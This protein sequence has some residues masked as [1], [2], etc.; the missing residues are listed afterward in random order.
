MDKEE[1]SQELVI[2]PESTRR[3]GVDFGLFRQKDGS[4]VNFPKPEHIGKPKEIDK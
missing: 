4:T 2:P 3:P 1:E